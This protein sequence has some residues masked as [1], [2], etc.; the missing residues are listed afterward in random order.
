[1]YVRV[2]GVGVMEGFEDYSYVDGGQYKFVPANFDMARRYM[3]DVGLVYMYDPISLSPNIALIPL[4]TPGDTNLD[5]LRATLTG[6]GLSI[7]NPFFV[8]RYMNFPVM[9]ESWC[10]TRHNF[11]DPSTLCTDTIDAGHLPCLE[12]HGGPLTALVGGRQVLIGV[13][14]DIDEPCGA[15]HH[16]VF[17]RITAHLSWINSIMANPPA[18]PA[19]TPEPTFFESP[20]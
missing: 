8:L 15:G 20:K 18:P 11:A 3:N 19:P 5:H 10:L 1:M 7:D 6:F 14:S 12:N 4:P 9:P 13:G 2:G 17:T 16:G